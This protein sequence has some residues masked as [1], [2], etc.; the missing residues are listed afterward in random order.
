MKYQPLDAYY[1]EISFLFLT[2]LYYII[3]VWYY[4]FF[5]KVTTCKT[6][7]LWGFFFLEV[8]SP[9]EG[10]DDRKVNKALPS[11]IADALLR[12]I[13]TDTALCPLSLSL[14]TYRAF[15]FCI[16]ISVYLC[17]STNC[18]VLF[19][20]GALLFTSSPVLGRVSCFSPF[21]HIL[22]RSFELLCVY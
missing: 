21:F 18:I 13:N 19:W 15:F 8:T 14:S 22:V 6:R 17:S 3:I 9:E 16:S 1:M 2:R 5:Y 10:F 11:V 7:V 4:Y 12:H 20:N